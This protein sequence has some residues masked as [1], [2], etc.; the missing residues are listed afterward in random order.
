MRISDDGRKTVVFFGIETEKG[1]QYG[2]TGFLLADEEEG[3]RMPFLVTC[4][5]VAV[6]LERVGEFFIRINTRDG[7]AKNWPIQKIEWVYHPDPT[8]DLA[9]IPLAIDSSDFDASYCLMTTTG[10]LSPKSHPDAVVCGDPISMVGLFRLHA[11]SKRNVPIVHSGHIAALPD[12]SEP[13]PLRD[14]VTGNVV[15]AEAYLVEAQTLDGLSGSPVFIHEMTN[16]TTH[17][18]AGVAADFHPKA[19]GMVRLLGLYAGSWDGE[20]GGIL[21]K[22]RTFQGSVRVPVGM[23]IVV[24]AEKIL[25]LIRDHPTIKA[26]RTEAIQQELAKRAASQG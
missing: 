12:P 11:G 2:G 26:L 1:I 20:P 19:Y 22:D 15:R 23:G 7:G 9:A 18:I 21:A 16:L 17:K 6:Q 25:E 14:R 3:I 5:H 24:P 10:Y 8:V 13:I 4:R